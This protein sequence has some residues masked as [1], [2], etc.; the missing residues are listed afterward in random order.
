MEGSERWAPLAEGLVPRTCRA[1]ELI[2][3]QGTEATHFY[4]MLEGTA[5]SFISSPAG[6]ERV[7]TYHHSGDLMGE[8]SFFDQCPRVSSAAAE[9]DCRVV[10]IDRDTLDQ[11]LRRH[12]E[13]ALPLLQYLARTVRLLSSQVD[14]MS[15][16]SADK[17]VARYLLSQT[18]GG[19]PLRRTHEEIGNA[20]GVS[21]VTISR[22]LGALVRG[23]LVETSYH[24]VRVTNRQGL[25]RLAEEGG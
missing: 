22:V 15:F 7:L 21:R 25:E 17:R 14:H 10:A 3:L 1:G 4:Y 5:R 18:T 19:E 2:Y 8:A 16:L 20:V 6:G 9:S 24:S 13:L 23:G 11:A 12:P